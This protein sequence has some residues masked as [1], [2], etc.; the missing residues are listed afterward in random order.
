MYIGYNLYTLSYGMI[1]AHNMATLGLTGN[2][3]LKE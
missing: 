1:Q 3:N 2:V